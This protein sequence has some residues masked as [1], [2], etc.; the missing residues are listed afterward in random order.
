MP[1]DAF[2]VVAIVL[3][4]VFL[5]AVGRFAWQRRKNKFVFWGWLA[6]LALLVVIDVFYFSP[7]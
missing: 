1:L 2:S 6:V 4:A 7:R 5:A 3:E